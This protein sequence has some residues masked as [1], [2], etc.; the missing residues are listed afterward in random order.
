M[1]EPMPTAYAIAHL[2]NPNINDDVLEYLE[3][4]QGTLDPFGGRFIVHG[5]TVEVIEGE[6]PGTIVILAFP[7]IDAARAWYHSTAYQEILHLRTDH[8]GGEAILAEGVG[9]DYDVRHTADVLRAGT[10]R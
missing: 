4:I 5:P 7:D 3:R 8:I 10:S 2:H 1:L 9:P 6:W